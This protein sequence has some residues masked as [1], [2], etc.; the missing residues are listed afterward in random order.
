MQ[1]ENSGQI[2]G[3][4]ISGEFVMGAKIF[5]TPLDEVEGYSVRPGFFLENGAVAFPGGVSFTVYSRYAESVTLLLFKFDEAEPFARIPFPEDYHIGNVYSMIVFGL[6]I[7][8]F[9]YAFSVDGPYDPAEGHIFDP[10]QY[11]ID[12]YGKAVTGQ[13]VWG[14]KPFEGYRYRSRATVSTFDWGKAA[15]PKIPMDDSIIYELHV[16]GFTRHHSSGVENPGTFAGLLEKIPYLRELGITCVELMPVFEFDEL[17]GSREYEG[18]VLLDYWGYNPVSFF[19][20]NSSYAAVNER[21]KEGVELK[22]L[23]K[24]LHENGIEVILDVV[25]NHTAEGDENGPYISFKG[26][27]NK[28][29]YML[30]PD[31]KYYNFSGCGN[32]VN[33][34][35]P[36][37]Q[38]MILESL[39]YWTAEYRVDGFRFDLASILGRD[40]Q[41]RPMKNPPLLKELAYDPILANVKLI[42]EAWDAGGLY[43][44]GTFPSWKRWSEW[45][46]K[47]RDEMRSFLKGDAGFSGAAA[48]RITGSTD[49]YDPEYRGD[50][51]SVNFITCHDGFT[52]MDLYSFNERH[53][54]ANGW[55]NS[56]GEKNNH[57]WNCGSE[58]ET[59]DP[60][61]NSLRRRMVKN[62]CAVL[63]ASRGTPMMLSGDE[64]CNT[65]FGNNNAYCQD[66]EISWLDWSLAEKNRDIFDFFREMI[67]VRQ[68]HPVLRSATEPAECGLPSASVHGFEPWHFD[69]SSENRTLGVLFAGSV[70]Q[71]GEKRDDIVY[72]ALNM[73]WEA[74]S[75]QLPE[76]PGGKQ[77]RVLVDTSETPGKDIGENVSRDSLD[78][79]MIHI[80]PRTVMLLSGI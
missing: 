49:L 65:Q 34:G 39:R 47:Y 80:A 69:P 25:F 78:G 57:S 41:G 61:I 68:Q 55:D 27:D 64:F 43:Q 56:D 73:H 21:N 35:N 36:I 54:H 28:T 23:I 19:A 66:N 9:E 12:P 67:V 7:T 42:A 50:H 13:S 76:L 48:R 58:G 26:F 51:A 3:S 62:A 37:V 10:G 52:L 79:D 29:Y 14:E 77:W 22:Q 60:E 5:Y 45:N 38:N 6:D 17:S 63:F 18:N 20:P 71:D 30:T 72:V 46:G 33:A 74:H 32:T 75:M 59:D 70:E 44:V 11:L 31:G 40:E 16:R 53:N 15:A 4:G 1:P 24:A 8:D 2:P